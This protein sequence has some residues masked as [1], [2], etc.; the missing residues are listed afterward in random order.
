MKIRPVISN[1]AAI[2]TTDGAGVK[3]LRVFGY[4]QVPTYDPFLMLDNFG[5]DDPADYI[6]GF[7]WHPHRGIETITYLLQGEVEHGDSMGNKGVIGPGDVQWMTAGSGIIHQEMPRG[8]ANGRLRGLQLWSNL[9]ASHKMMDPRYQ[10]IRSEQIPTVVVDDAQIKVICGEVAGVRG[11][12]KDI[13]SNPSFLDITIPPGGKIALPVPA[14]HN[15]F[16]YIIEGSGVFGDNGG[17]Q[18]SQRLIHFGD[19]DTVQITSADGLRCVLVH[20]LP[21]REPIS[22]GGPIVMN[23]QEEL[24][25]AF[26]EYERGTFVK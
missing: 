13:I 4:H 5:G 25:I 7:P 2:P 22:W 19:G 20:G 23:T 1:I 8:D 15:A 9:P 17:L 18:H 12:V 16:C 14:D 11:P 21:I 6:N 24:R 10:D 3:L 26:D